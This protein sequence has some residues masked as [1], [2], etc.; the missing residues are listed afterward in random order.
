[1]PTPQIMMPR[2]VLNADAYLHEHPELIDAATRKAKKTEFQIIIR[3]LKTGKILHEENVVWLGELQEGLNLTL[4]TRIP[5]TE[6]WKE[7]EST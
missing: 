5:I 6:A 4:T 3:G 7:E 2:T 1:M